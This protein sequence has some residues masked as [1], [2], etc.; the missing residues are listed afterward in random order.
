MVGWKERTNHLPLL[1]HIMCRRI[2][3]IGTTTSILPYL[4]I[5]IASTELPVTA[6]RTLYMGEN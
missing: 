5:E 2:T 4:F 6:L 1:F 3:Q